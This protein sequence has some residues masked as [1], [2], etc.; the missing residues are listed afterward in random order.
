MELVIVTHN[1]LN[2]GLASSAAQ[3]QSAYVIEIVDCLAV[4]LPFGLWDGFG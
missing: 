2:I 3:R 1:L 4:P